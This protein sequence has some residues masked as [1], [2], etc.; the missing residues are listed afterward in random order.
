[1][2]DEAVLDLIDDVVVD[3]TAGEAG[4]VVEAND[5]PIVEE[6]KGDERVMPQWI[7]NLKATDQ[8]AFKEAK[9]IFFGKR[10]MDEKLKDF[11]L[12]GTKNWLAEVGGREALEATRTELEGKATEYDGLVE[13][14]SRGD[15]SVMQRI[16]EQAG[17]KFPDMASA[18]LAQWSKAFPESYNATVYGAL[19]QVISQGQTTSLFSDAPVT[20]P[21]LLAEARSAL[22]YAPP[23]KQGE[24]AMGVMARLENY[25]GSF[26]QLA[27]QTPQ[28]RQ[29]APSQASDPKQEVER[30]KDEAFTKDVK[31]DLRTF[32]ETSGKE[33]LKDYI[34]N[35]PDD[36]D[37]MELSLAELERR[38]IAHMSKDEGYQK[39]MKG[40][41]ARRDKEGAMRLAKSRESLAIKEIA[42]KVG[43]LF[44][45]APKSTPTPAPVRATPRPAQ[46]VPARP[47][48][49]FDEIWASR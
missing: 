25:L 16:A 3:D 12:D 4:D 20:V 40:F 5:T 2:A 7:R 32:R 21:N 42:P 23:E 45:G 48:S 27:Q 46:K 22:R 17:D 15:G 8:A 6:P 24:I 34:K 29:T 38:V 9:A 18:A 31:S 33:E 39:A 49:R 35:A 36:A 43:K 26:Q 44:Y 11:D 47:A 13:A 30:M 37:K 41:A 14:V 1:M 19:S 28:S 10:S